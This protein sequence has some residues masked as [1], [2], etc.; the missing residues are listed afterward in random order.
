MKCWLVE[1]VQRLIVVSSDTKRRTP[2]GEDIVS[3]LHE[4][5]RSHSMTDK[6]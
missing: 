5:V 2:F 4:S 1:K 6:N 3:T